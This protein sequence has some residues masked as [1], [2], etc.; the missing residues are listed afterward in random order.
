[1]KRGQMDSNV[2]N[3]FFEEFGVVDLDLQKRIVT[4]LEEDKQEFQPSMIYHGESKSKKIATNTRSSIFKTIEKTELFDLC[5]QYIQKINEIR[6]NNRSPP[7]KKQKIE[8]E[9][10]LQ[11]KYQL[12]R[13]DV[14]YIQYKKGDFFKKHEDYLSLTSNV[15][16]EYTLIMCTDASKNCVGGE[17]KIELNKNYSH[18]STSTKTPFHSLIFR[19]D[20][21]HEGF[22]V[23]MGHK[24][25]MTLNLWKLKDENSLNNERVV[26]V[27]FPNDKR[28]IGLLCSEIKQFN[29]TRL[30]NEIKDIDENEKIIHFLE[31]EVK[32]EEFVVLY[33]I[34]KKES[35]SELDFDTYENQIK[36]YGFK[37]NEMI[38]KSNLNSFVIPYLENHTVNEY[39][40]SSDD[41]SLKF[42]EHPLPI[43]KYLYLRKEIPRDNNIIILENY[44][45]YVEALYH[46]KKE[47]LS[48][49]PFQILFAEGSLT[50]GGDVAYS[51]RPLKF[52]MRPVYAAFGEKNQVMFFHHLVST[53]FVQGSY[54]QEIKNYFSPDIPDEVSTIIL[55]YDCPHYTKADTGIDGEI[56]PLDLAFSL[57]RDPID[58]ITSSTRNSP[59]EITCLKENS[60]TIVEKLKFY[61]LVD[62]NC[63][64]IQPHQ[65][66]FVYNR[67]NESK[68][69]EQIL[70]QIN[71]IDFE[72]TQRSSGFEQDF[73]NEQVYGNTSFLMIYGIMN[74]E[75]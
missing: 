68:I 74:M 69:F 14:T 34:Y 71:H 60:F 19:K 13:N 35:I 46:I 50:F 9:D 6:Q 70:S 52:R 23:M 33:K 11:G 25:I 3:N 24:H 45:K 26:I 4:F 31:S 30:W 7:Q 48:W 27:S 51:Q 32:F 53:H 61:D 29:Q 2:K 42:Y 37:T 66:E 65:R 12:Y 18:E 5:D 20:L 72:F 15:I 59:P 10:S 64:F 57:T 28:T 22:R 8:K 40:S 36:F 55:N 67:V 41:E 56:H 75:N 38:I 17:T 58:T 73:C 62:D 63:M 21:N 54:H 47:K 49:I 44:S 1:M 16:E 39:E 43:L